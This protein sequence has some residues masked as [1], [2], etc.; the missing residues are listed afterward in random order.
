M[1]DQNSEPEAEDKEVSIY[2]QVK[3]IRI[4]LNDRDQYQGEN[5]IRRPPLFC[6]AKAHREFATNV[7]NINKK[8]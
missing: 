2:E 1:I 4:A 7:Q 3:Q 5:R 8:I 6:W